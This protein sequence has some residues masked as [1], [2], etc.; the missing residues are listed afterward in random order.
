MKQAPLPRFSSSALPQGRLHILIVT[1]V[2]PPY[3]KRIWRHAVELANRGYEVTVVAP[4]PKSLPNVSRLNPCVVPFQAANGVVDR[5]ACLPFRVARACSKVLSGNQVDI[6]H[7]HDIDLYPVAIWLRRYGVPMVYDVHE[8]FAQEM[9]TRVEGVRGRVGYN[10][11]P[12]RLLGWVGPLLAWLTTAYDRSFARFVGNA[13]LVAPS[14]LATHRQA[15]V[16]LAEVRNYASLATHGNPRGYTDDRGS[17]VVFTG[18]HYEE[19]GSLLLLEIAALVHAEVP[20]V[21]FIVSD[22]FASPAFR[23]RFDSSRERLRLKDVVKII[24]PV[25]ADKILSVLDTASVGLICSLPTPRMEA[26]IPTRLFEYMAAGLPVVA[27][28]LPLI[29]AVLD[30]ASCGV[31]VEP[32]GADAFAEAII[33]LLRNPSLR[34]EHSRAARTAFSERYTWESQVDKLELLYSEIRPRRGLL[35]EEST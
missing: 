13:V 18:S 24:D 3:D 17:R 11:A 6:V 14:Q 30:D 20:D 22:L 5:L 1:S 15:E 12:G 34:G 4:W 16:R 29:A 25:P 33:D 21:E 23:A 8:N 19:N 10:S 27:P 7:F 9:T 2:H 32:G 28:S 31:A 26:G 35:A